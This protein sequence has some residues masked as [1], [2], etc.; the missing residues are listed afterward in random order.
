MLTRLSTRLSVALLTPESRASW[1]VVSCPDLIARMSS[2]SPLV[3]GRFV[4]VDACT[5]GSLF[6]IRNGVK[7]I[8]WLNVPAARI[9]LPVM[10][11]RIEPPVGTGK[12]SPYRVLSKAAESFADRL[13]IAVIAYRQAN[14]CSQN[15]VARHAGIAEGTLAQTLKKNKETSLN[16]ALLLAELLRHNVNPCWLLMGTGESNIRNT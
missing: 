3:R 7:A 6:R 5:V 14:Q 13:N 2:T 1:L 11:K 16:T 12:A 9:M 4:S 15:D 10:T 8:V